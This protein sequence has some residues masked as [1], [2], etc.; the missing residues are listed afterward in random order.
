[1]FDVTVE[2]KAGPQAPSGF[3]AEP[4]DAI[5]EAEVEVRSIAD[6][7]GEPITGI[8]DESGRVTFQLADGSYEVFATAQTQDELCEWISGN[9]VTVGGAAVTLTLDDM[10]VACQ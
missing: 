6:P 2:V 7:D 9:A 8:T 10:M 3:G 4:G 5:S 1:M